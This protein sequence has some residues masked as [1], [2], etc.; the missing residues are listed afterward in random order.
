MG[1]CGTLRMQMEVHF[2]IIRQVQNKGN[3]KVS[4]NI[5]IGVTKEPGGV[6]LQNGV[7]VRQRRVS[8]VATFVFGKQQ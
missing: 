3:L 7:V 1:P 6:C 2:P 5:S 8:Q 4:N